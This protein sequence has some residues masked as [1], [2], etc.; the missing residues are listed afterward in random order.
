MAD[1]LD[2]LSRVVDEN[3]SALLEGL[4]PEGRPSALDLGAFVSR[5]WQALPPRSGAAMRPAYAVDGS[6]SQIDLDN[7]SYLIIAQALCIGQDAFEDSQVDVQVLP[8]TTPRPT[9][10]RFA[11]L[12]QRYRELSLAAEVAA[13]RL[14]DGSLLY[15]DGALY[16]LLPQLFPSAEDEDALRDLPELVLERY[17]RLMQVARER[18]IDLVA[19]AKTSREATHAKIWLEAGPAPSGAQIPADVSDSGMLQRWTEGRTGLSAP[20]L[21]GRWGFT[22]GSAALLEREDLRR[23]PAI[24]S[25]FIRLSP[26]DEV[27]RVDLPGWQ[28]GDETTLADPMRG[29]PLPGGAD[30]L[31]RTVEHLRQDYGGPEVYNALLYSVD[32]EVRL[33]RQVAAE[34]YL[35]LIGQ[36]LALPLRPD[37]SSRRFL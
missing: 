29:R 3:R 36:M 7:G 26:W 2:K 19:I 33:R 24:A 27:L 28:A 9:A 12:V 18:R 22:G 14:P 21:L 5:H 32:R 8:P 37:R 25:C 35:P 30:A 17:L 1:F 4:R 13:H 23:A 31:S 10:A 16:G 20:V 15:L 6:L 11:D 34:V